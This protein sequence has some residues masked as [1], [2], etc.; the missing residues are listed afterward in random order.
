MF[1]VTSFSMPRKSGGFGGVAGSL[2]DYVMYTYIPRCM[3]YMYMYVN[4]GGHAASIRPNPPRVQ[5]VNIHTFYTSNPM[6]AHK[7][8]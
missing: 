7:Q 5:F 8:H 2:M 6:H 3:Y 4:A 1:A